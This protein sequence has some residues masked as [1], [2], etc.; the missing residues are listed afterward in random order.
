M[1]RSSVFFLWR[2]V[3]VFSRWSPEREREVI[4]N[5]TT[6]GE[7]ERTQLKRRTGMK[8]SETDRTQMRSKMIGLGSSEADGST[9]QCRD[10]QVPAEPTLSAQGPA[11]HFSSYL[12][13]NLLPG[14]V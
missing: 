10:P 2:L 9:S 5:Y 3:G 14:T 6:K 7:T 13:G 1:K 12:E 4:K 11:G 8:L